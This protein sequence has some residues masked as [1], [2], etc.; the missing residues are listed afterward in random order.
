MAKKI[1]PVLLLL[2]VSV[3]PVQAMSESVKIDL[4]LTRIEKSNLT[5]IRNGREYTSER[6]RE[7]L[8]YKL[9]R[10]SDHIHTARQFIKH[11]ATRSYLTGIPYYVRYP[12]GKKKKTGTW[13]MEQL[14]QIEKLK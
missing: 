7:H 5:F 12:D 13:L 3:I 4:L 6:A 9:S 1:I 10:A 8:E 14:E 11:I 2:S